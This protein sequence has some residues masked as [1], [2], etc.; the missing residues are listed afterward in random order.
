MNQP[1]VNGARYFILFKDDATGF[2]VVN[3]MARKS[4]ALRHFK[5]FA[6]Q[7]HRET[8]SH[9]RRLRSDRGAEYTSLAFR[10]YLHREG[11]A[12]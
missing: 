6:D 9:V 10:E 4:E 11:I 8:N 2:R 5:Q 7:L 12:Q 1:T 3:C